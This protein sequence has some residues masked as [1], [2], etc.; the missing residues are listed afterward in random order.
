MCGRDPGSDGMSEFDQLSKQDELRGV[1]GNELIKKQLSE[2]IRE[3]KV[4]QA[5]MLTGEKGLGKKTLTK[6]FLLE[7][8][9]QHPDKNTGQPC[10]KCPECKKILS[11]NHP[12]VITVTHAKGKSIGVGEIRLKVQETVDIRPL[13]SGYKVYVIPDAQ[14]L[15]VQAQNA[16]LK[17]LEEPPKYVV[18]IL[19]TDDETK[20]LDTIRSRVVK[21][22]MKPLTDSLVRQYLV[23][24]LNARDEKTEI[25]VAFA[26]GNLGKAIWL[27]QDEAFSDWY[28]RL[29]KIIKN[30][31]KWNPTD[32]RI[33]VNKL[34]NTCSDLNEA[35]DLMEL[36]YRDLM[37]YMVTKD[38]N[39]LVF[40]GESKTFRAMASRGNTLG[41]Q[42]IMNRIQTA[43]ERLSANV[44]PEL[45]ME[46]LFL[47]I[48]ETK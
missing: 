1:Y 32:I 20:L 31:S 45:T 10:L 22:Q 29:M 36:W 4:H 3:G 12:D 14:L 41:V 42:E 19:I 39:G 34:V 47:G 23:E 7:L 16:L 28:Q 8:Y 26:R 9:C 38:M 27:Y 33:E 25:C 37:L 21:I 2:N 43:R 24:V 30:V 15:T 40:Y 18:F 35:L 46:L 5:Y 11:F 6:N 13:E 44:S 17:V 48:K